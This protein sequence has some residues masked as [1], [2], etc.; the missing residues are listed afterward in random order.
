MHVNHFIP[1][2]MQYHSLNSACLSDFAKDYQLR[3]HAEYRN[4]LIDFDTKL[5]EVFNQRRERYVRKFYP[6]YI[7]GSP[8]K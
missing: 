4:H 8:I 6:Q 3:E 5:I 2:F 1:Y 7:D